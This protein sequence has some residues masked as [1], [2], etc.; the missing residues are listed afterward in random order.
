MSEQVTSNNKLYAERDVIEQMQHYVNHVE[1]MTAEGL[2][3][4]SDIAAELAHRDIVIERL[5]LE[6]ASAHTA[7]EGWR[8]LRTVPEP[9]KSRGNLLRDETSQWEVQTESEGN[10]CVPCHARVV[11]GVLCRWWGDGNPPSGVE[12]IDRASQPPSLLR[13]VAAIAYDTS[14]AAE[15]R[16]RDIQDL[17]EGATAPPSA[18]PL[19]LDTD[20]Q[21]FFYEQDHYYLSNFSAF[22]LR[23]DGIDFDTSEHAY[24]WEKFKISGVDT[25]RVG[26]LI[27]GAR[28]AHEAFKI[29]EALKGERRA[30]WDSVK[31][32]AMR[33]ILREKARQ[34]EYVRRKLLETGARQLIE[35]SWRDDYWGWGEKR[36][37]QNML[38]KL[39]MEI[40]AELHGSS[41][42]KSAALPC[43]WRDGCRK[44]EACAAKGHCDAPLAKHGE[45]YGL[46]DPLAAVR[47]ICP[48]CTTVNGIDDATCL[49]C[50]QARP[51]LGESGG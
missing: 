46:D 14:K 2:H 15:D 51:S 7:V 17:W 8:Q 13:E 9:G 12:L 38:G 6:L 29:A 18:G 24:H 43:V 10:P 36:D 37:G 41:Q 3:S 19:T 11:G 16:I 23:W 44:P 42:T 33:R 47:W 28:S 40:R 32:D 35:N 21:V 22:R 48:K 1:A 34:H 49:G 30:D 45:V 27:Y 31:V 39:W 26:R 50:R 20:S 4:K 25:S 5:Q